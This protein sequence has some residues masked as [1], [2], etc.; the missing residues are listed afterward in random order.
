M[1]RFDLLRPELDLPDLCVEH[2]HPPAFR[3]RFDVTTY[4]VFTVPSM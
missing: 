2:D 4:Q 1:M 3:R